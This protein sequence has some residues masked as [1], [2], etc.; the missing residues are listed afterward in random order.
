MLWFAAVLAVCLFAWEAYRYVSGRRVRE[1]NARAFDR[2]IVE[3][4]RLRLRGC[5]VP[6]VE[7]G[8]MMEVPL[9]GE[10][11]RNALAFNRCHSWMEGRLMGWVQA[12]RRL[13]EA[14]VREE[15]AVM[16]AELERYANRGAA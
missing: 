10:Q 13:H 9:W 11:R 6:P 4:E 5:G 2:G 7:E 8:G 16:V 14:L 15:A 3:G 1:A 12:D